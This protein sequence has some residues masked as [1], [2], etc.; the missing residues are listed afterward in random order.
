[1]QGQRRGGAEA[2]EVAAVTP[3]LPHAA[4]LLRLIWAE[5]NIS[6]AE[7]ARR[8]ELSRS[9]VSETVNEL[10]VTGLVQEV[11]AGQS[12]RGRRPIVLQFQDDAFGLVG[13]DV[14]ASH[15][16]VA[17]TNL[18]GQVLAW[19]DRAHPVRTDPEGTRSLAVALIQE[20]LAR[21]GQG[22]HRLVGI[23]V[24]VPAPVDPRDPDRLSDVVLPAWKGSGGFVA[25]EERFGVPVLVDNDANLGALAE[26]WWGAGQGVQDVA[27]VKLGTGIGSGLI[28]GGQIY[29]GATGVA[30][31][32]GHLAID[33]NGP[34]CVCGLRGC[35]VTLVGAQALVA[36]AA[37]LLPEAPGSLLARGELSLDRIEEAALA[38]DPLALRVV[39]DAAGHLGIAVAGLLNLLNPAAV[40][41]G[42]SLARV[43]EALLEPLR[44]TVRGRTLVSSVAAARIVTS[45][46]GARAIA[47]GAATL[48]LEA[49]LADLT[50]FPFAAPRR[51][52]S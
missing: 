20:C 21:W 8:T 14:G 51:L 31:E 5:R 48:A 37:A 26:R 46:L 3:R 9:T 7:I 43:G 15:V 6:R 39:R 47:L 1:M 11:G 40:I 19:A 17:L 22:P 36:R 4:A 16:G 45:P 27:Y 25:L 24:A 52:E 10:L 23:G 34:P 33:P 38:A 41:V 42:G 12:V 18:R 28:I 13:V 32:I 35:L 30:G 44:A 49:A 50:R 29:R 2:V